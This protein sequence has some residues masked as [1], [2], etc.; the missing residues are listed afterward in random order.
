M[1]GVPHK[2]AVRRAPGRTI[3]QTKLTECGSVFACLFVSARH[4]RLRRRVN[5]CAAR[6]TLDG[7]ERKVHDQSVAG[8]T[9]RRGAHRSA[10]TFCL[11]CTGSRHPQYD[12]DDSPCF[13]TRWA[14]LAPGEKSRDHE[15]TVQLAEPP[16]AQGPR[17]SLDAR[18]M[19]ARRRR[20]PLQSSRSAGASGRPSR[21]NLVST[22]GRSST[23]ALG[24]ERARGR[25]S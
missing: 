13:S 10:R 5:F 6:E 24:E 11:P 15:K 1:S 20:R 7:C 18:Y 16:L 4:L 12:D 19:P 22:R 8:V 25:P 3:L 23:S 14:W 9:T 21:T 17:G 2:G